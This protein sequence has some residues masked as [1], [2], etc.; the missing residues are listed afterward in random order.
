VISAGANIPSIS[1]F[2]PIPDKKNLNLPTIGAAK[3]SKLGQ[4]ATGS[5][6]QEKLSLG[7]PKI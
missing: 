2:Y 3:D 1:P 6:L 4:I 7:T 5:L